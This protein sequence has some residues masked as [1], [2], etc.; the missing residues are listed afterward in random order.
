MTSYKSF[1]IKGFKVSF[2]N[3]TTHKPCPNW[4]PPDLRRIK[5]MH[6][7]GA[8]IRVH[9]AKYPVVYRPHFY[10]AWMSSFITASTVSVS[11]SHL[12][13][14]IFPSLTILHTTLKIIKSLLLNSAMQWL[15]L[16]RI[17]SNLFGI[18][19]V[20]A[21]YWGYMWSVCYWC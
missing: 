19:I 18:H 17:N 9:V 1:S 8:N 20:I 15:R 16:I 10:T 11:T 13:E 4:Q 5:L 6:V 7:I 12:L 3:A 21:A 2:L 14:F